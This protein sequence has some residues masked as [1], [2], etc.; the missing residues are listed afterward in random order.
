MTVS[1]GYIPASWLKPLPGSNAGL[2]KPLAY[3]YWAMHYRSVRELNVSLAIVDGSVG[4]TY[5]TY[6][7]QVLAK[8]VFGSNAATP[9]TSN[10][11]LARAVD[12]HSGAQRS[13][14][15]RIG[16]GFGWAKAWSDASWEWWHLR[17]IEVSGF[18]PKPDPFRLL[19]RKERALAERFVYH[20]REAR[21]EAR[22]GRGPRYRRHRRWLTYYHRRIR[23]QMRR[24]YQAAHVPI[25]RGGG[26]EK[27]DRGKR[28]QILGRV[29]RK[30][31]G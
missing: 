2:V 11:G 6:A 24:I 31:S 1:N 19:S 9:G 20:K 10:H 13:A 29:I 3:Q 15:D 22:T 23:R 26:W 7:R 5:R 30:R 4:R 14:I 17:G 27:Y 12:L 25:R 18:E 8:R 28:Y 21:R 16:R